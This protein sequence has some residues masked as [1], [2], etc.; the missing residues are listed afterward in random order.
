VLIFGAGPV[1]ISIAIGLAQVYQC[2][3]KIYDLGRRFEKREG[4][5]VLRE[6]P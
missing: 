4:R 3:C 2:T 6:F 5:W 1:G